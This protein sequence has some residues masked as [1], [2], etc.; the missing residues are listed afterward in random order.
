MSET[1]KTQETD[2]DFKPSDAVPEV[3]PETVD[4][5]D[6]E[7]AEAADG[8]DDEA[9][10]DAEDAAPAGPPPGEPS[11]GERLRERE[12][13][14]ARAAEGKAPSSRRR[15]PEPSP[16]D[17]IDEPDEELKEAPEMQAYPKM[18]ATTSMP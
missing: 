18:C 7:A 15:A 16:F 4:V 13:T 11:R 14:E 17:E 5:I 12:R 10:D 3:D 9:V 6:P 1:E 8:A 2:T